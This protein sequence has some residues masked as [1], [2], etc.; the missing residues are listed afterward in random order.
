MGVNIVSRAMWNALPPIRRHMI[1][2]P[3]PELW[4]HHTAGA[5]ANEPTVRR[6]QNFHMAAPPA[7]RGWSDIAYSFLLDNDAPDVDIFEGRGAGVAGGH[8][9][10]RNTVSHAICIIGNYVNAPPHPDTIETLI[11]LVVH[12]HR[13]GWWPDQI[14][15][16]HRD[17][18]GAATQCPGDALHRL[19]PSINAEIR[20]R[21]DQGEDDD[22]AQ[23]TETQAKILREFADQIKASGSNGGG[24]AKALID[25]YR[26]VRAA[27][28]GG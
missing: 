22:M 28:T 27:I 8:T 4:L 17:A 26:A 1:P 25:Y 24:F 7:G 13:Q 19:I 15:G 3:T 18:P 16:G 20:R 5:G 21:L 23:F 10:G 14:T 12:G 11:R 9:K 6:I 2:L